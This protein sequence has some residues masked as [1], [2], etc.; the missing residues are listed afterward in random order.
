LLPL[1]NHHQNKLWVDI[2]PVAN[3]YK[4]ADFHFLLMIILTIQTLI[5]ALFIFM[6]GEMLI[7]FLAL[8]VGLMFTYLFVYLYSKNRLKA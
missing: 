7:A 2:Y 4:T 5:F 3:K 6:K 1:W 8:V